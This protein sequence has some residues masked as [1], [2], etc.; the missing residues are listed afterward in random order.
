MQSTRFFSLF[1]C[2]YSFLCQDT[3]TPSF[4]QSHLTFIIDV[5][6]SIEFV[7]ICDFI[8]RKWSMKTNNCSLTTLQT[9][10]LLKQFCVHRNEFKVNHMLCLCIFLLLMNPTVST[11][12]FCLCQS[13]CSNALYVERIL[14]FK[15]YDGSGLLSIFIWNHR[16]KVEFGAIQINR[17]K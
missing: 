11:W 9:T 17:K 7:L 5:N 16:F 4:P 8:E 15:A 2:S 3:N 14:Q 1:S 10:L 12:I 6:R 13:Q